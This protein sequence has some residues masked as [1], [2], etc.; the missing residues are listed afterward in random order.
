ML[1]TMTSISLPRPAIVRSGAGR[2]MATFA[3]IGVASTV[4]YVALYALVRTAMPAAAANA[5]ALLITAV[6]N[7]AANRRL[8]FGIRGRQDM[9]RDHLAGILAFAVA[10]ALTSA[11]LAGL[12]VL[13]PAASRRLELA[14]LLGSQILA[15]GVRFLMLRTWLRRAARVVASGASP[16]EGSQSLRNGSAKFEKSHS[17]EQQR[18]DGAHP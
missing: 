18:R 7:T 2:E 14:V 17:I 10:L 6:G 15:T 1:T 12:A 8:T 5:V 13:V 16:A 4:A 3:V 9:A 11:A